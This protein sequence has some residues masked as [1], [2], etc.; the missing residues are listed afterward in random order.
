MG[1]RH[2]DDLVF[3]PNFTSYPKCHIRLAQ[4][5]V[6]KDDKVINETLLFP[7]DKAQD[8]MRRILKDNG[9]EPSTVGIGDKKVSTYIAPSDMVFPFASKVLAHNH[10]NWKEK[11]TSRPSLKEFEKVSLLCPNECDEWKDCH[12]TFKTKKLERDVAQVQFEENLPLL[13]H[14]LLKTE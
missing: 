9:A 10:K 3:W 11:K 13:P 4:D 7:N 1:I 5:V 12:M 6:D 8:H 2:F 14:H